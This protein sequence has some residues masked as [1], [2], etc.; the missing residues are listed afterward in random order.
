MVKIKKTLSQISFV[1][2]K[3]NLYYLA[4]SLRNLLILFLCQIILLSEVAISIAS[5][6]SRFVCQNIDRAH[7]TLYFRAKS[8]AIDLNGQL[9]EYSGQLFFNRFSPAQSRVKMSANP[10]SI[11][12]QSALGQNPLIQT[13]LQTIPHSAVVFTSSSANQIGP[14][15]L[16]VSGIVQHASQKSHIRF[17]V[18]I[19]F[20]SD[21]ST[22]IKGIITGATL[23]SQQ[24]GPLGSIEGELHFNLLF[25]TNHASGA[26]TNC[27]K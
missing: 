25:A 20:S 3:E 26:L 19:T 5:P 24:A 7:S 15:R 23:P 16:L 12:L 22:R 1:H 6:N 21:N 27:A 18:E 8:G 4:V 14:Q 13:L 10:A 2:F 9:D 17:P 11:R